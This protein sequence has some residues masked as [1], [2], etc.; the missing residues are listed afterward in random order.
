MKAKSIKGTSHDDIYAALHKSMEDGFAPTLAIVFIS[1]K[2]DRNVIAE[3]LSQND[4][5]IFGVTSSGEFIDG[6]QSEGEIAILLLDL[7]RDSYSI[8]YE[9]IGGR[10]IETTSKRIAE[11]ALS[12]FRNPKMIVCSTGCNIKGEFLGF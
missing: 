2:K 8:L 11:D 3:L 1:I 12:L 9:D 4:I 6:H 5:D 10:S 7:S